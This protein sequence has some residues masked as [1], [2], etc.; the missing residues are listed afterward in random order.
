MNLLLDA[1]IELV[2]SHDKD[3]ILKLALLNKFHTVKSLEINNALDYVRHIWVGYAD[4]VKAGVVYLCYLPCYDWW[5][6]DAYKEDDLLKFINNAGNYSF[7]A[8]KLVMDWFFA[9]IK[10][11]EL[12]TVHE[13][14]NRGA[15]VVCKKL[16]FK[17]SGYIGEYIVL[18]KAR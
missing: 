3:Y 5:T 13:R 14:A 11:P 7:R 4:G 9:N 12:H 15:T 10:H 18:K 8:G 17:E 16:G 2:P 6:L 1:E